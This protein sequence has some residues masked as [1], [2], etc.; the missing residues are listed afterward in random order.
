MHYC[1]NKKTSPSTLFPL[2]AV[3]LHSKLGQSS[4]NR[5]DSSTA[6]TVFCKLQFLLFF[7]EMGIKLN[8]GEKKNISSIGL[9]F[10]IV[11]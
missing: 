3:M 1:S 11:N 9:Q 5:E 10:L 4:Q 2:Q 7:T 6:W 8:V